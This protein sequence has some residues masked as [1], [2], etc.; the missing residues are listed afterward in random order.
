[1]EAR[2]D[3]VEP[4]GAGG[5][6]N[7][8]NEGAFSQLRA[9]IAALRSHGMKMIL[10]LNYVVGRTIA[11]LAQ[12]AGVCPEAPAV[13]GSYLG[14][15][16]AFIANTRAIRAL[17]ELT[18]ATGRSVSTSRLPPEALRVRSYAAT[19]S[20]GVARIEVPIP[21]KPGKFVYITPE[22]S[23]DFDGFGG[24]RVAVRQQVFFESH[25][26]HIRKL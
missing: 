23:W 21:G 3:G 25:D 19:L 20:G 16:A 15:G 8:F 5:F 26:V 14:A 4:D 9:E 18:E 12:V 11:G 17:G 10:P 2:H 1:M 24:N 7:H 6:R 13:K 22:S